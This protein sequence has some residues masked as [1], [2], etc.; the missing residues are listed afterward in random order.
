[1]RSESKR[2]HLLK[3]RGIK[4]APK[5]INGKDLSGDKKEVQRKVSRGKKVTETRRVK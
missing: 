3:T 4:L 2:R 5:H 1:M